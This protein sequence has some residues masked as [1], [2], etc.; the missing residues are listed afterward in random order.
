MITFKDMN[1]TKEKFPDAAETIRNTQTLESTYEY[2]DNIN[3][4]F[5]PIINTLLGKNLNQPNKAP[6]VYTWK[7]KTE[8]GEQGYN[9][10]ISNKG[11][12]ATSLH[13]Y[14]IEP[15][16]KLMKEHR[17][18]DEDWQS[19]GFI[20]DVI[21]D[22]K[23]FKATTEYLNPKGKDIM[24]II[25]DVRNKTN[26]QLPKE[27]EIHKMIFL[28]DDEREFFGLSNKQGI[29]EIIDG[30]S[31]VEFTLSVLKDKDKEFEKD[32]LFKIN[33]LDFD[34]KEHFAYIL[35]VINH[36]KDIEEAIEEYK[37]KTKSIKDAWENFDEQMKE[38]LAKYVL[39]ERL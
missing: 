1:E 26:V 38:K 22:D 7:R 33:D 5:L 18:N 20:I 4:K 3:R 28:S 17:E 16:E 14:Q 13:R 9:L 34:D 2:T 23:V 25:K 15:Y 6:D 19:Q 10:Q 39:L 12:G 36:K 37:N 27:T 31:N 24:N 30:G 8:Y 11:I 29:I 32:E 21:D 35:F